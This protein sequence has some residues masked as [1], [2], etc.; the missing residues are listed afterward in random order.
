MVVAETS[1]V[2]EGKSANK[3][4]DKQTQ[5]SQA[6]PS[7]RASF[8]YDRVIGAST[9][10]DG[11]RRRTAVTFTTACLALVSGVMEAGPFAILGPMTDAIRRSARTGRGDAL[12]GD[13]T[14]PCERC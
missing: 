14:S 2:L 12:R 11:N 4:R 6:A 8:P 7:C 13:R 1:H 3:C 9:S 10:S 5:L